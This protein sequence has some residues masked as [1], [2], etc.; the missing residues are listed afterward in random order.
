MGE[1]ELKEIIITITGTEQLEGVPCAFTQVYRGD[2]ESSSEA[3]N[4]FIKHINK[5]PKICSPIQ[6][7][8]N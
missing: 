2:F 3:V 8:I 7:M 4:D 1:I 6:Q 5:Y